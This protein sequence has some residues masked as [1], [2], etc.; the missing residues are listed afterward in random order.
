MG[1]VWWRRLFLSVLAMTGLL[2]LAYFVPPVLPLSVAVGG[3][4][5][6]ALRRP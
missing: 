6:W 1:A 3:V 4:L 2:A 5:W